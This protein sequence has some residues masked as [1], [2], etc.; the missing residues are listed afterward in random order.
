LKEGAKK[1]FK[2]KSLI[3]KTAAFLLA[4]APMLLGFIGS[5]AWFGEPQIPT[6]YKN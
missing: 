4:A 3:E 6:Q 1:M 2:K 5:F